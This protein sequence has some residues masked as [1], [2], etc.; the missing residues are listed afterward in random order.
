M[1]EEKIVGINLRK[2][3]KNVS[4]WRRKAVFGRL[5]RKKLKDEKIKIS[6]GLNEKIWS[7]SSPK[8]RLKLVKDEKTTKAE[9]A[10]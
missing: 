7:R 8:V 3:L 10:E 2:E 9:L 6:Q 5:I 4:R 1:A